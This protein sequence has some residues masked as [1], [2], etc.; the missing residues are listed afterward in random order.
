MHLIFGYR[1]A[2]AFEHF[3]LFLDALLAPPLAHLQLAWRAQPY[4]HDAL[5]WD[6]LHE[7]LTLCLNCHFYPPGSITH[8]RLLLN[9]Y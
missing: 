3:V 2:E 8:T 5:L 1:N 4:G 6:A 7:F 9:Y